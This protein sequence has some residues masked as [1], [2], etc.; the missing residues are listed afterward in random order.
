MVA[1]GAQ[2]KSA[3]TTLTTL[4]IACGLLTTLLGIGNF[5]RLTQLRDQ[6]N[7]LFEELGSTLTSVVETDGGDDSTTALPTV[8]VQGKKVINA[9]LYNF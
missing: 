8:W 9:L 4:L 6:Q 5:V 3:A 7:K 1:S 2:D